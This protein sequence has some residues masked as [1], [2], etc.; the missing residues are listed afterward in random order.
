MVITHAFNISIIQVY[1]PTSTASDESMDDFYGQ[2][3]DTLDKIPSNMLI[4]V[5]D[6]NAKVGKADTKSKLKLESSKWERETNMVTAW[7]IFVKQTTW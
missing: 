3:Q 1:A 2:L 6:W 5:G 4:T 7:R